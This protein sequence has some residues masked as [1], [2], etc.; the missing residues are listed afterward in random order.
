MVKGPKCNLLV[1]VPFINYYCSHDYISPKSN[2]LY[3][4]QDEKVALG[5]IYHTIKALLTVH[6]T[7]YTN[8]L[9]LIDYQYII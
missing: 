3:K 5:T 8:T 7:S 2:N 9:Q 4:E 6:L 1:L